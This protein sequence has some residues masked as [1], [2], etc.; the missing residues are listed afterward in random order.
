MKFLEAKTFPDRFWSN[1]LQGAVES[2]ACQGPEEALPGELT[3]MLSEGFSQTW[4]LAR[5]P[6]VRAKE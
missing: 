2:N 6:S 5:D 3:A 4:S 1:M